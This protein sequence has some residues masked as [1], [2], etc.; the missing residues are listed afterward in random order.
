VKKEIYS[1]SSLVE[2]DM[3]KSFLES[4]GIKCLIWDKN[5]ATSHPAVTF[6]SG[7]RLVVNEEDYDEEDYDLAKEIIGEYLQKKEPH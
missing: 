5:I 1:T 3:I 6:S 2:A 4:R 7:I